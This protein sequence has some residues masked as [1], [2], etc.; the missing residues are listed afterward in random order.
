[1]IV[2]TRIFPLRV[3]EDIDLPR[4]ITGH[5]RLRSRRYTVAGRTDA[6]MH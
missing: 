3:L 4:Q 5:L 1:M 2:F 6:P